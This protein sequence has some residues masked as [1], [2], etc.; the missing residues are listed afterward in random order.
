IDTLEAAYNIDR[1]RI[2]ANG[3]SNG[4]A[5]AYALSCRLSDRI[6][7]VGT[8]SGGQVPGSWCAESR[9][10]PMMTFHGTADP[11]N[12][13]NGGRRSRASPEPFPSVLIWAANWAQRNRCGPNP[14]QSAVAADVTRLEYTNCVDD[15][16][17]V[18]YTLRGGGHAWPGPKPKQES[19][20]FARV[21]AMN[22]WLL[23]PTNRNIDATNQMWAFF[24]E[25]PLPRK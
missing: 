25:H 18:L 14:I 19:F 16:A 6:A 10:V 11:I 21:V 22:Q 4:G 5:M 15:A 13:Y 1:A 3:A 24:R 2:Y 20:L 7:A 17:V 8:V 12:P 23:G 9:P